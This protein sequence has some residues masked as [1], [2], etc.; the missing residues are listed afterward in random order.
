MV[1]YFILI[2]FLLYTPE[3]LVVLLELIGLVVLSLIFV[4]ILFNSQTTY[5]IEAFQPDQGG[6]AVGICVIQS[7][8]ILWDLFF[9]IILLM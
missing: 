6:L 3:G 7:I 4:I 9:V 8:V 2:V 5:I 1:K